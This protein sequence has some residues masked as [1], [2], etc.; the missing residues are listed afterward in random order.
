[1]NSLVSISLAGATPVPA[2]AMQAPDRRALEAYASWLHM[3]RRL[4]CLELWPHMGVDAEKYIWADNAGHDW[5]FRGEGDWRDLPQPSS[6]AARVLDLVR[7]DW[8]DPR[9]GNISPRDNGLRPALPDNWPASDDPIFAAIEAHK[10][11]HERLA[12]EVSKHSELE[13]EIPLEKRQ[14]EVNPWEDEF[15]VETD[16]PRWI[17][18]ERALL[19]AFDAEIEAACALCE[20]RPKTRPGLMALLN[21]ALTHDKD[22]HGWPRAL[23]SGDSRNIT[24]SWHHFLIENVTVALTLGLGE[25]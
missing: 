23:E 10:H 17:A 7:V 25:V 3:E 11:I 9:Y 22:G 16:D 5:H 19:K 6:R 4:L 20:I 15:I 21:Y 14:S 24:R 1:M 18:S 2:P 12:K 8:K 13:Q